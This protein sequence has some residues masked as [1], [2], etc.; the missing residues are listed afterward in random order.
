MEFHSHVGHATG[1]SVAVTHDGGHPK[2]G[3]GTVCRWV[4]RATTVIAATLV[5]PDVVGVR[6][7]AVVPGLVGHHHQIPV[8]PVVVQ[9]GI[10]EEA[11]QIRAQGIAVIRIADDAQP[12][13]AP[14][15]SA[16]TEKVRQI[17]GHIG[18][19]R[20]PIFAERKQLVPGAARTPWIGVIPQPQVRHGK[21]SASVSVKNFT[22][23][24]NQ[25]F[26]VRGRR[27]SIATKQAEEFLIGIDG[28]VHFQAR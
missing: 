25:Q 16:S 17:A 9:D 3:Y 22:H 11:R 7:A 6:S 13:N 10:W 18:H 19:V 28:Q 24:Q 5:D 27:T 4:A 21:P 26:N 2:L 8:A 14:A 20:Q 23:R 1:A 12:G 15:E